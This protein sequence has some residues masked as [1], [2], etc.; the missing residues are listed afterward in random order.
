MTRKSKKVKQRERRYR[1]FYLMLLMLITAVSISFSSYAWFSTN[2]IARVDLLDVNVRAQGGIEIS[3]D[4]SAWKSNVSVEDIMNARN[5]YPN[6]VNQ[7][8]KTLEP[9]STVGE[10][11]NGKLKMFYGNVTND[12]NG[13]YILSSVRSIETESFDEESDGLFIA[14]DLFFKTQENTTFY[15]TPESNITYA[16]DKSYGTENS[17]RVAFVVEGNTTSTNSL[18]N[19]QGL[20]T[21]SN[22]DVFIWE[23]NYNVHTSY[24]VEHAKNTYGID[25]DLTSG[26][27]NYD[28]VRDEISSNLKI[29]SSDAISSKY[30]EYFGR[31]NVSY[32]T[33]QG[34]TNNTQ[35]FDLKSGITKVRVY[36]WIEGQDIDC[37]NNASIGNITLNLQFS[38]NP[39]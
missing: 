12:S 24:A 36:M 5:T 8:P 34:F 29:K 4:G 30:P 32:N 3:V 27:I 6:S 13:D 25:T 20:T 35:I 14:F 16:G 2:R 7:I 38:K 19:I 39:A 17:V 15:L 23:P 31:V 21:Y 10:I 9:V 37:E 22:S 28:G 1:L 18:T 33:V 26:I 11:E